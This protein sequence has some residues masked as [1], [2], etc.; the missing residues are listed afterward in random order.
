MTDRKKLT[1]RREGSLLTRVDVELL[2]SRQLLSAAVDPVVTPNLTV[3]SLATKSA[4]T[5]YTP[6]QIKKAYGFN[7]ISGDGTGQ[8]IAIVDAFND[9]NIA[10]DLKTFDRQFGLKDP[11]SLKVVNQS[12]GSSL[13]AT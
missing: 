4:F 5:G 10:S 3:T 13:P 7:S 11:P 9:P 6:E 8:T 1:R 2:E 12:G